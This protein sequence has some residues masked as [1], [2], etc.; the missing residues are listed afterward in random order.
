LK[1]YA[2]P[3]AKMFQ[4]DGT[5]DI[6]ACTL[7]VLWRQTLWRGFTDSYRTPTFSFLSQFHLGNSFFSIIFP[8][9]RWNL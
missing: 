1:S 2:E 4:L 6:F 9:Q 5:S 8:F 7:I 3:F